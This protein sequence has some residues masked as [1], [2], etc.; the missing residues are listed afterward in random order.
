MSKILYSTTLAL[1]SLR[2]YSVRAYVLNVYSLSP[3]TPPKGGA[4]GWKHYLSYVLI[5]GAREFAYWEPFRLLA[6]WE[7]LPCGK[8][9]GSSKVES[10]WHRF[11]LGIGAG[12][13]QRLFACE[14]VA[15]NLGLKV[16]IHVPKSTSL[17]LTSVIKPVFDG[18]A[19]AFSRHEG[20]TNLATKR[21]A[22]ALGIGQKELIRLLGNETM[23]ILGS[24]RL[25][26]PRGN[27]IQWNP[28]DALLVAGELSVI[29]YASDEG[30]WQLS[31]E[32]FEVRETK[33]G[34]HLI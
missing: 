22:D 28:N 12:R 33:P 14:A 17:N 34:T 23:A 18:I 2:T 25:V 26:Y 16:T 19:A 10:V 13:V 20:G 21:L 31:G 7:Q 1:H 6:K 3:P 30:E 11:K 15:S 4:N 8:M 32:L 29:E 27:G 9:T 24:R 5:K